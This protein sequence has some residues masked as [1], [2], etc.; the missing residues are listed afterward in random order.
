L[1]SNSAPA[2]QDPVIDPVIQSRIDQLKEVINSA[3]A[4]AFDV[5]FEDLFNGNAYDPFSSSPG[6]IRFG[7]A[8]VDGTGSWFQA[9][10]TALTGTPDV[11][12]ND[13]FE[14]V[15]GTN[16]MNDVTTSARGILSEA[17]L[18]P[19]SQLGI[20]LSVN[21]NGGVLADID[22]FR[23]IV[24]V[25]LSAD[26]DNDGDVDGDDL[27]VFKTAYG[28]TDAADANGDGI[29]DG[30]D[31]LI[32]QRTFGNDATQAVVSFSASDLALL[33][34]STSVPEPSAALLFCLGA[35]A[36]TAVGGAGR[37]RV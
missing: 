17:G 23:V 20:I 15:I 13:T 37:F 5:H 4:F 6:W 35:L 33:G 36:T 18:L 32:W 25:D 8:V 11:N 7:L 9:E 34:F 21:T 30:R 1:N 24:P 2:G 27:T 19:S 10:G 26:F 28:Q 12:A 31:F 22:N 29:S 14:Y 3:S 16:I